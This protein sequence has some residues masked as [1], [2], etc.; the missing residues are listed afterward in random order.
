MAK[1]KFNFGSDTST[2]LFH[3]ANASGNDFNMYTTCHTSGEPVFG[4]IRFTGNSVFS[5]A[6]FTS[7][8]NTIIDIC[9]NS[10]SN[11]Y[12]MLRL[13]PS[14]TQN[15]YLRFGGDLFVQTVGGTDLFTICDDGKVGIG[16]APTTD[17]LEVDTS[18]RIQN[19][20]DRTNDFARL[21]WT[22]DTFQV[23]TTTGGGYG[24]LGLVQD[25]SGNVGIGT[26]PSTKLHLGG[27]N[28]VLR[29]DS[30][31]SAYCCFSQISLNNTRTTI[32]SCIVDSTAQG[33]TDIHFATRVSG[34]T[35]TRMIV[36]HFGK[37]GIGVTDPSSKLHVACE[38]T[39][40][41]DG[42][43]RGIIGYLPSEDRL[44]FGTRDSGTNYF[45]AVNLYQGKLGIG[46]TSPDTSLSI[47]KAS[48]SSGFFNIPLS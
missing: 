14:G 11:Y 8:D 9:G 24:N 19:A 36:D 28:N 16:A 15:S 20:S 46:D 43:N 42:S 7:S 39:L 41:P 44:Y 34:T 48:A 25:A 47:I 10:G 13:C 31:T 29:I 1:F 2:T 27:S 22:S 40:G 35:A 23:K 26:T 30:G 37:V 38:M 4:N 17:K 33:D 32:T 6:T 12:S 3:N 45:D 18:I 5:N 21:L